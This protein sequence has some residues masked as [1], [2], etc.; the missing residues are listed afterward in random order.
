MFGFIDALFSIDFFPHFIVKWLPPNFVPKRE[1][2]IIIPDDKLSDL[3]TDTVL[4]P[5]LY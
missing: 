3:S 2:D 5:P 4:E 1:R